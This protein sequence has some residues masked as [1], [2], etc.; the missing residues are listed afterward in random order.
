MRATLWELPCYST[1]PYLGE[2][3]ERLGDGGE[4]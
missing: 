1:G 4:V 3:V 2:E